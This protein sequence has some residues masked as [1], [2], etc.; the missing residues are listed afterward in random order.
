[1]R[2]VLDRRPETP[3]THHTATPPGTTTQTPST[4]A[5]GTEVPAMAKT[6]TNK[7]TPA[8]VALREE[9]ATGALAPGDWLPSEA[10]LMAAH[11]I[12]RYSAREALKQLLADGLVV[13]VD[14]KGSYVRNRRDRAAHTDTRA[15]WT[16][17]DPDADTDSDTGTATLRDAETGAGWEPVEEPSTYRTDASADV[18]LS[19]GMHEHTPLFVYDRLLGRNERR[20]SHRLY[21]PMSTCAEVP[22][23]ADNPFHAPDELYTALTRAGLEPR[24]AETVRAAVPTPDDTNTLHVPTGSAV[25]IT[26]RLITDPAGRTLAMEETRRSGEDT[27]LAYPLTPLTPPRCHPASSGH[28]PIPADSDTRQGHHTVSTRTE[29]LVNADP[30]MPAPSGFP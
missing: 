17:P 1:M 9:I 8:L 13:I 6:G 18:A 28:P 26:R 22:E 5:Q 23:L 16:D 24:F 20:V 29:F 4:D 2:Q 10:Q 25:L 7:H 11:G 21:L 27:Q 19:M 14:G 3:P 30:L 12:T 15:I